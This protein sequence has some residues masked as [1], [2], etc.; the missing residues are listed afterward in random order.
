[1]GK[2]LLSNSMALVCLSLL[3][4]N[5]ACDTNV[6]LR[7]GLTDG[8]VYFLPATAHLSTD[9][10]L[11]SWVTYSL[12]ESTCKLGVGGDNPA[13]NSSF[14]CEVSARHLLVQSWSQQVQD[15]PQLQD[16]YLDELT[17]IEQAGFLREYVWDNFR[18]RSW[19][20]P[21]DLRSQEFREWKLGNLDNHRPYTRR[22]GWWA[23]TD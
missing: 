22:I 4:L 19:Q 18:E 12:G 17:Q 13:R 15:R 1:M 5:T 6:Y 2:R 7:D 16:R 20:R 10:A 3:A 14:E 23:Y 11:H 8:D 21:D 9:P